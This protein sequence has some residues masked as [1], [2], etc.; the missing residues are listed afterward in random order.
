MR[1]RL[2]SDLLWI[3]ISVGIVA[4]GGGDDTGT[5]RRNL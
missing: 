3:W 2:G 1:L 5:F 4:S